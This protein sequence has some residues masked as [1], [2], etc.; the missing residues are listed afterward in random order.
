MKFNSARF[1]AIVI[2]IG[3]SV[4]CQST[5]IRLNNI[6]ERSDIDTTKGRKITAQAGGFQLFLVIPIKVNSRQ[7]RAYQQLV[8]KAG[9]DVISDVKITERWTYGYVGTAYTTIMEA[10]A[11][12]RIVKKD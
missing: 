8:E 9:N 7:D 4:G 3:I 1:L 11:Y 2:L 6:T 5:P 12:P 10:M